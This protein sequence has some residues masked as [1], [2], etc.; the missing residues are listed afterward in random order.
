MIHTFELRTII[1]YT[2]ITL[3]ETCLGQPIV[4]D[5]NVCK[6]KNPS[7]KKGLK[8]LTITRNTQCKNKY[9]MTLEIE[10]FSLLLGKLSIDLFSCNKQ[11]VATLYGYIDSIL[12]R[13]DSSL[14]LN[15]GTWYVSRIDYAAQFK[16]PYV[17]TYI[18]LA[19]K[20]PTPR[21]YE[22]R[23][24][25]GSAYEVCKSTRQNAYDK[26]DQLSKTKMPESIKEAAR[27]LYRY[28]VQ[29]RGTRKIRTLREKY[30]IK[31][32]N[33][34]GLLDEKIAL[35]ELTSF[36][37]KH[38]KKGAYHTLA[39]ATDV[40]MS[41][42]K[43][44]STKESTV[45]LLRFIQRTGSYNHALQAIS[46]QNRG[47]IPITYRVN[48]GYSSD[49]LSEKFKRNVRDHLCKAD[50]NPILLPNDFKLSSLVNPY[51]ELFSPV[52]RRGE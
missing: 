24:M 49:C 14:S 51:H 35:N 8:S 28:E 5:E 40:I 9:Y 18:D 32:N 26:F 31:A 42:S 2:I 45:E 30:D 44:Q 33:L 43:R 1:T 39:S 6:L 23:D 17:T 21:H 22:L 37:D 36:Y 13:I 19:K 46:E 4:F 41:S 7:G 15:T 52:S 34:F 20:A 25:E 27:N 38:V 3:L 29:C 10:P 47:D 48:D 11:N 12:R 16:T 50:I